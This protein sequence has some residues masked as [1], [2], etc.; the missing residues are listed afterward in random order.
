[1]PRRKK[2]EKSNA[3][4]RKQQQHEIIKCGSE[5][6]Y[7]LGKY[8]KIPHPKKGLVKFKTFPFQDDCLQAFQ[9]HRYIIVNKSRQLG[10]STSAAA[11]ALWLAIFRREKNV[12]V[13]ATKLPTAQNFV[14][15]VR[16][17][18][19]SLPPWLVMPSLV[20][21]NKASLSFSNGSTIK[22]VPCSEDAGRSEA[23][24]LLIVDEAAHIEGLN[25]M[26]TAMQPTLSCVA[27]DTLVMTDEGLIPIE[28]F[29][30]GKNVGDYFPL[31]LVVYGKDGLE[32]TS[33]GYVSP[34]HETNVVTTK[35]GHKVECT[36]IHPLYTLQSSSGVGKMIQS[37]NLKLGDY[38]RIEVG[39]FI[40]GKTCLHKDLA[41]MLGGY[42]AEG[43]VT[44]R[45]RKDG[46][47]KFDSIEIENTD[48]GFRKAFLESATLDKNFSVVP[49][50]NSR[51]R[52]TSKNTISKW[53]QLGINPL[54][55]CFTKETPKAILRGNKE[56]V[57]NYLSGLFDGDGSVTSNGIVLS[58]T[59]KKLIEQTNIMLHNIGFVSNVH[60]VKARL[61]DVG[62]IMPQG[63]PLQ[64]LRDSWRLVVPRSQYK[65][66]ADTI[67]FRIQ[68]K[69]KRL[70]SLS[71]KYV[72][73]DLKL[74]TIPVSHVEKNIRSLLKRSGKTKK[75]F[76]E[77]G[78]RLDKCLDKK[79][80][81]RTITQDWLIKFE[82]LLINAG[83]KLTPDDNQFMNENIGGFYW[84]PITSIEK[85]HNKTYDFTV[86]GTHS[87]LQ[88]GILGSNTGGSV[89]MISSPSGV[90]T[91]FHTIW[92][93]AIAG[94]N[95][96]YPIELPWT[97][98]PERDE[99][100]FKK[101]SR[102]LI[103]SEG[104]RG[105]AQ[106]LLCSFM[107]SGDTFLKGEYMDL[108][109]KQ[110]SPPVDKTS[111]GRHEVWTWKHPE[112]GHKYIISADVAR[113]DADDYS[114]FH[115]LDTT[116][117]E[118]VADFRGKL[119]PDKFADML[120][121]YGK[122]YNQALICQELNNVGYACAVKL[123]NSGYPNLYYEKFQKNIY[124]SYV[125]TQIGPDDH[126]GFTTS[127]NTRVQILA[128]LENAIRNN[129]VRLRSKRLYEE[130]QTFIWKGNKPQA[131]KNHNDDLV[132]ALAIGCELFQFSGAKQF[133][134]DDAQWALVKG[135]SRD[136]QTMDTNTGRTSDGFFS[137][138]PGQ[139]DPHAKSR[140]T[141]EMEQNKAKSLAQSNVQD[142]NDP[143]WKQFNWV[144]D[145]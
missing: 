29:H 32:K 109:F 40:Y 77:N 124:M 24:S 25:P 30:Q 66:F 92:K 89:I 42:T 47:W 83:L 119:P 132:M 1:V 33:H 85:S 61:S 16:T 50:R 18:L 15:K 34:S 105:V 63:K 143:M 106:E 52:L 44:K 74:F 104:E 35:H 41:Y 135:M 91:L 19:K 9:D 17:M 64:T 108:L 111:H 71:Q 5:V 31:E 56:T 27:G 58:S 140:L 53:T 80:Q 49:S 3:P 39:Q 57:S 62:R 11:Y 38:M 120:V 90:G 138:N 84:D 65:L 48:A 14:K 122:K 133:G 107:S 144:F 88:N 112:P 46:S 137:Q 141:R 82:A 60:Y 78:L 13:V 8:V 69:Q 136:E 142:Y 22:A 123:K 67:G 73:D 68:R 131:Q 37:Q 102:A 76:R 26:W 10:L 6:S 115:V 72:Q 114:A 12:L 94:E 54:A 129:H 97:V 59:S 28:E 103:E 134:G 7:F 121:D 95:D 98:H 70:L 23:L 130:L 21:D 139:D 45:K 118:I 126:P 43:W 100:W 93:N 75:W 127:Q 113:G 86:P 116:S 101:E 4:S 110:I 99:E 117:E 87:F 55:R 51:L 81:E 125:N 145:D 79:A 128:K 96:F 20:E 2:T 36:P